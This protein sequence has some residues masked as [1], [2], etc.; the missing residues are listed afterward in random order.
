M[1]IKRGKPSYSGVMIPP[2]EMTTADG[3]DL[4]FGTNVLG[5]FVF[6]T[7]LIPALLE[8]AQSSPDRK[9]RVVNTSSIAHEFVNNLNWDSF[10]DASA[11]KKLGTR[12]MYA[13]S[14]FVSNSLTC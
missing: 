1:F 2:I 12:M 10:A 13:Q 14:K 7:E 6:T 11:R 4:Q 8:G 9:A 5:H 3:F